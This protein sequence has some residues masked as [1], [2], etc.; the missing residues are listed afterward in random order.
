MAKISKNRFFSD[1]VRG[2]FLVG[3]E[4]EN[5]HFSQRFMIPI[6][7]LRKIRFKKIGH[8]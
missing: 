7:L 8:F 6:K 4:I 1:L 2:I 3:A 5:F